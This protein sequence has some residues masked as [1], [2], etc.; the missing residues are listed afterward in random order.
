[1]EENNQTQTTETVATP[2]ETATVATEQKTA[3][4]VDIG[5]IEAHMAALKA[6][7]E[8]LFA[9]QIKELE[10][11]RDEL[12]AQAKAEVQAVETDVQTFE[13]KHRVAI[14]YLIDA[15]KIVLG[16]VIAGKFLGVI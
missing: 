8:E 10:K 15:V 11:K 4:Q 6:D 2:T 9:D 12:V 5:K 14:G 1:M 7:G 3:V 16:V 13:Q